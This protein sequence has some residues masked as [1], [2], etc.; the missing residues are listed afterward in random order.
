MRN[1]LF[2]LGL[3]MLWLGS[4]LIYP[5]W[6]LP[7]ENLRG[8]V[9][10]LLLIFF[11]VNFL[12][13]D[14]FVHSL[15]LGGGKI[16]YFPL[17][18][19]KIIW[20]SGII[21]FFLQVYPMAMPVLSRNDEEHYLTSS[22]VYYLKFSSFWERYLRIS[23]PWCAWVLVF[24]L[25]LIVKRSIWVKILKQRKYFIFYFLL[26]GSVIY[27]LIF[28]R[29]VS[30]GSFF[31]L[32]HYPLFSKVFY[33]AVYS[34]FGVREF[35]PRLVQTIF[36]F[37]SAVYLYKLVSL[38]RSRE[39]A[40]FSFILWLFMPA[41]IFFGN[42]AMLVNGISFFF[43]S[44]FYYLLRFHK[45]K[46]SRSFFLGLFILSV[47]TMYQQPVIVAL[48]IYYLYLWSLVILKKISIFQDKNIFILSSWVIFAT[49]L[50]Y[51]ILTR[52]IY[53]PFA[54]NFSP[55]FIFSKGAYI[56][57][58]K[59]TL[60][61][62][63]AVHLIFLVTGIAFIGRK[64]DDLSLFSL[65]WFAGYFLFQITYDPYLPCWRAFRHVV[66]CF[67]VLAIWMAEGLG[68]VAGKK[69]FRGLI[70]IVLTCAILTS[71]VWIVPPISP[72]LMLYRNLHS[73]Y[74]PYHEAILYLKKNLPPEEKCLSPGHSN[75][76]KFYSLKFGLSPSQIDQTWW[77]E[78][79]ELQTEDNLYE[80]AKS[81][82]IKF[83][84]FPSG[85]WPI[86]FLNLTL[87]DRLVS[88]LD[89]RFILD[90]VFVS[91]QNKLY[92]VEVR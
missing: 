69:M 48:F 58:V 33:M 71:T 11:V 74:V 65:L 73:R 41:C 49:A 27:Y 86:G 37:L 88:G 29:Y 15:K 54:Y 10:G 60:S 12:L 8:V 23:W 84:L 9:F 36:G 42:M 51:F 59:R 18:G 66:P 30:L 20:W 13:I 77:W 52:F 31:Y 14:R 44:S 78:S 68:V 2:P 3:F 81:H 55:G 19:E 46:S 35:G 67:P 7:Q 45:E 72:R 91:G 25:I 26:L 62:L 47:G 43:I 22:L 32:F 63:S 38:Y 70:V 1:S 16:P 87:R 76:D 34:L 57:L 92:L 83:C 85:D 53:V 39:T 56:A 82:K 17:K 89:K 24:L 5:L 4:Y 80:Y 50:P 21:Y 90:R 61:G 64:R 75:P 40:I 79:V 6:Y 28:S